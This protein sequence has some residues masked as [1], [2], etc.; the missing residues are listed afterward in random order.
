MRWGV[1][2]WSQMPVRH[3]CMLRRELGILTASPCPAPL[4]VHVIDC[5]AR[6]GEG[7]AL[8]LTAHIKHTSEPPCLPARLPPHLP[9]DCALLSPS[10]MRAAA[11]SAPSIDAYMATLQAEGLLVPTAQD[12]CWQARWE[13]GS[14]CSGPAGLEARRSHQSSLRPPCCLLS[15]PCR[16]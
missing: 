4:Q 13:E 9:P 8:G 7:G 3:L 1:W 15:P 2:G 14:Q 10:P 6:F 16:W 5:L 11:I 12:D